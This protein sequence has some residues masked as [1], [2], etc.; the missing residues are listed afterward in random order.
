M[1]TLNLTNKQIAVINELKHQDLTS[2]QI[3]NKINSFNLILGVYNV[4]DEL[5]DKGLVDSYFK[6]NNKYHYITNQN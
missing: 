4:L 6:Q 2:F 5:N 1:E 3:L